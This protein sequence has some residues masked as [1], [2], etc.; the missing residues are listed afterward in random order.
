M[1]LSPA[2]TGHSEESRKVGSPHGSPAP[3]IPAASV[4]VPSRFC[5]F[6]LGP[7]SPSLTPGPGT[8]G[9]VKVLS[10]GTR[11]PLGKNE[12][13]KARVSGSGDKSQ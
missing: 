12:R 1:A 2:L 5:L 10:V 13:I 9:C 8:P 11:H 4:R 3:P 7:S 6:P